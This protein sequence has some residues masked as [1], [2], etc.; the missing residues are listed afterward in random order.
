MAGGSSRDALRRVVAVLEHL[1][2]EHEVEGAVLDRKRL[3]GPAQ[4]G[5]RVVDDVDGIDF[6]ESSKELATPQVGDE[7][8]DP[9]LLDDIRAA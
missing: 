2:A 6:A 9:S 8:L 3:D 1:R 4:L 5:G 7:L